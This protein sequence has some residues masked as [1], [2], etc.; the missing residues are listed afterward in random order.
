MK[1][2]DVNEPSIEKSFTFSY[3][4]TNEDVARTQRK[5]KRADEIG[6]TL[7]ILDEDVTSKELKELEEYIIDNY[8]DLDIDVPPELKEKYR[9]LK[10]QYDA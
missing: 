4:V 1:I 5:L 2:S 9:R 3:Q 8:I 6:L 7:F 10:A